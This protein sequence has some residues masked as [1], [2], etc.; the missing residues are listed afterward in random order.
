MLFA[1]LVC[2]KKLLKKANMSFSKHWNYFSW[3]I[4]VIRDKRLL[5]NQIS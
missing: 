5:N 3:F 1:C 2:M 4:E